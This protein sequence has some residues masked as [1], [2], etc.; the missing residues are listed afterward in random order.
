MAP[1][2]PRGRTGRWQVPALAVLFFGP[3]ILAW[4][5]VALGWYPERTTNNGRL[6]EP[7]KRLQADGWRWGDG[8]RFEAEW[9][10]GRWSVLFL[11]RGDCAE[12]C[13]ALLDKLA[14]AR[15]A[16]DKDMTRVDLLLGMGGEGTQ[17]AGVPVRVL[18]LPA[19]PLRRL[20]RSAP[21]G[22]ADR[23]VYVV[24]SDGFV[25][26]SYPLPLETEGL[27]EDLEQLLENADKDVERIQ[28]LRHEADGS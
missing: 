9:F 21:A 27:V 25:M 17:P 28:R 24:D 10:Q 12:D 13:R 1:E 15:L 14:R 11:Q 3:V 5:L 26:M 8:A 6:V 18:R 7:P 16:L 23:A 4:V 22:D 20:I 19:Q 2:Q